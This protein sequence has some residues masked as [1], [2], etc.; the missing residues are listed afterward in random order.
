MTGTGITSSS[1]ERR[2]QELGKARKTS[3]GGEWELEAR[4]RTIKYAD[5]IQR[6]EGTA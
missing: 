3:W 4:E 5:H 1:E 2:L 6:A